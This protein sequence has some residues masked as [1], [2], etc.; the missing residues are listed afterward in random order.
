MI[1]KVILETAAGED[2][3][4]FTDLYYE[5]RCA[6]SQLKQYIPYLIGRGML[7]QTDYI[8]KT[9]ERGM[10]AIDILRKVMEEFADK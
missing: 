3:C 8:Y 1:Y 7:T 4:R 9:T 10:Q 2:G 6:N 5:S